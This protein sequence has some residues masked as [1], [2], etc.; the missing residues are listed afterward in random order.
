MVS[1][2]TR[3]KNSEYRS[4]EHLTPKEVARLIE[5]AELRGRHSHRDQTLILMMF[6]HGLRATEASNLRWDA[7]SLEDA[8]IYINRAK[9]SNSG[10]HRLQADEIESL[11]LL[12]TKYP[13]GFYVFQNERG[14]QLSES[15]IAKVVEA[16]GKLAELPFNVHPHMMRHS[17]GYF[18][19][20]K[21]LPTRDI[22]EYLGH[23]NIQNTVRYTA[24]NPAR[25]DHIKW[26]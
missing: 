21:G 16:T 9:G 1:T 17:C 2:P 4:R 7:I 24:A 15:S 11:K 19:A 23:R 25:F 12:R 6:R 8:S 22:Q 13:D 5:V 10:S 3:K 20:E 26:G 14:G 18:L